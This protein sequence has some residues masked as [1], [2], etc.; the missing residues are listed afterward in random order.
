MLPKKDA[1]WQCEQY[2]T[3]LHHPTHASKSN[4]LVV[5]TKA[6]MLVRSVVRYQKWWA[7]HHRC[8][9]TAASY[10]AAQLVR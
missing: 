2:Q 7:Y 4:S 5:E 10:I 6:R 9:V 8:L 1:A 3:V